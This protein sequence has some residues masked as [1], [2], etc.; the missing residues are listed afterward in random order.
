MKQQTLG[1]DERLYEDNKRRA[2]LGAI[3]PI[4][5]I[6]A[7]AEMKAAQQDVTTQETQVLQQE[8]IL[9]SVLTRSGL[10]NPGVAGARIV[11]TDHVEIPA[12]DPVIPIQDLIAEANGHRPEFEQNLIALE[13]AR[14][15]MLGTKSN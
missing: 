12:Q 3:A 15:N 14:L 7:E 9:K 6:Q 11:T 1:F 8:M 10:D 2:D 5:I 4:D 13:N